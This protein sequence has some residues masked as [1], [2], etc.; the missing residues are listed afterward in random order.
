[1]NQALSLTSERLA[2]REIVCAVP[3]LPAIR[4]PGTRARR[5]VPRSLSTTSIIAL[6]MISTVRGESPTG[7][8]GSDSPGRSPRCGVT[9]I[10]PL[11]IAAAT[12][13]I[14]IGVTCR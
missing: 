11:A 3:V 13:A 12:T 14:W 5:A 10:P 2:S 1:M 9:R 4:I 8:G 6:R 7:W